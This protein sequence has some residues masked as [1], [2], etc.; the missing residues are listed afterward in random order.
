M[1]SKN[2]LL[3][4]A[5]HKVATTAKRV[6]AENRTLTEQNRELKAKLASL[7]E[8]QVEVAK[9]KERMPR[10]TH[11]LKQWPLVIG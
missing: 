4:Q 7:E 9:W 3:E 10:L 1:F 5:A 8:A 2:R 11:Y 6:E